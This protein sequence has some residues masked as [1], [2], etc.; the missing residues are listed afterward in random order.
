MTID[1]AIIARICERWTMSLEPP[2][3]GSEEWFLNWVLRSPREAGKH[4]TA[5]WLAYASLLSVYGPEDIVAAHEAFGGM[6][7]QSLMIQ[8]LFQPV[9]HTVGEWSHAG[10]DHLERVLPANIDVERWDAYTDPPPPERDLIG[11][12]FGDLT[13]WRTKGGD[14]HRKLLDQ[15]FE[16]GPKA[17]VFTDIAC[18][19][20][21][22]HRARYES[23]LGA[24]TCGSYP[25]YLRALLARFEVLYGYTLVRGYYDRWSTV[26]A[27]V[28]DGYKDSVP[29]ELIPTPTT[30]VGLEVF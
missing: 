25:E 12:D 9:V 19:Y 10:V 5:G 20:L 28:P 29:G 24:A 18:R 21:H 6:G 3:D 27:L 23:L 1:T 16:N 13:A 26:M 8:E 30:P 11:L 2:L 15:V 22:L 7:A 4:L 14:T 17:V